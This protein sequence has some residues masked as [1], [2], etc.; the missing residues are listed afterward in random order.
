MKAIILVGGLGAG[1]LTRQ[2]N[3]KGLHFRI[4]GELT[5]TDTVMN[6]TSW[7]GVYPGLSK[8]MLDFVVNVKLAQRYV[9]PLACNAGDGWGEGNGHGKFHYRGRHFLAMTVNKLEAIFGVN[10]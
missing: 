4:A 10:F 2:P 6:D 9:C 3:M 1:S 5:N 7:I 8:E